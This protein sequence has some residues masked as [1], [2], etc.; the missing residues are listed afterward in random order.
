MKQPHMLKGE[1]FLAETAKRLKRKYRNP[2]TEIKKSWKKSSLSA[3][4][5][6]G[7]GMVPMSLVLRRASMV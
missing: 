2:S 1:F 7:R 4:C 5:K 6:H 3:L